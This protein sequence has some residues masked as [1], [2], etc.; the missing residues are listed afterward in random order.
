MYLG[1]HEDARKPSRQNTMNPSGTRT[2]SVSTK[3]FLEVSMCPPPREEALVVP[4]K[5]LPSLTVA[6]TRLLQKHQYCLK[7]KIRIDAVFKKKSTVIKSYSDLRTLPA[8]LDAFF[9]R[10]FKRAGADTTP[11]EFDLADDAN[12]SLGGTTLSE[13]ELS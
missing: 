13:S 8:V 5:A 4:P 7:A 2:R 3:H 10:G 6:T 12:G 11:P 1:R 9:K